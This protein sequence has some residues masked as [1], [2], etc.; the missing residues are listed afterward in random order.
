LISH[1]KQVSADF[2]QIS[3]NFTKFYENQRDRL[4]LLFYFCRIL[5]P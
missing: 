4:H 2:Y 5:K 3:L 1:P